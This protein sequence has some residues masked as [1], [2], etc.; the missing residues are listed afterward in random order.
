MNQNS[1]WDSFLNSLG[2]YMRQYAEASRKASKAYTRIE[3]TIRRAVEL[4]TRAM[5]GV[6]YV[7]LRGSVTFGRGGW[8][9]VP[10]GDMDLS[11]SMALVDR[12]YDKPDEEVRHELNRAIPEY[13]RRNDH[14]P[15]SQMVASWC[16]H[17]EGRHHIFEDTLWAHKQG[18]YTLSIPT[19]AAQVEGVLRDLTQEYGRGKRKWII[20]FNEAFGF[21]YDTREPPHPPNVEE[22]ISGFIALPIGERYKKVEEIKTRYTLFRINELYDNGEFSDPV[23]TS[24]V[25]RH[26][27]LHGVFSNFGELESLRLF[28]VLALLH[29]AVGA[30]REKLSAS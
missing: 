5:E 14:A 4:A 22:V 30:Y 15:L 17:F 13:F 1:P 27:I 16:E 26:A 11:E 8:S 3:P 23:F 24:K 20:R 9:E 7:L 18:R 6:P 2:S 21:E 25:K 12:L 10:L 28:F 29:D 19:L